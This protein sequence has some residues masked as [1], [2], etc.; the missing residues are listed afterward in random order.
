MKALKLLI[1]VSG[2]SQL[3]E[4][5]CAIKN[6][7]VQLSELFPPKSWTLIFLMLEKVQKV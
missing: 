2:L 7:K 5:M 1:S 6:D 4:A 3:D